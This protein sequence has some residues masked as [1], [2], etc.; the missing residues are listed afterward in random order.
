MLYLDPP[1]EDIGALRVIPVVANLTSVD[2]FT[3]QNDFTERVAGSRHKATSQG[4][5]RET[6]CLVKKY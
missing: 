2:R 3:S 1:K 4:L 6:R 5:R